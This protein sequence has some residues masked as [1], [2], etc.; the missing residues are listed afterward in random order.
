MG[1]RGAEG[2]AEYRRGGHPAVEFAGEDPR[3]RREVGSDLRQARPNEITLTATR[4]SGTSRCCASPTRGSTAGR[5]AHT[6]TPDET[7]SERSDG[8]EGTASTVRQTRRASKRFRGGPSL[9]GAMSLL[10]ARRAWRANRRG[11]AVGPACCG[12]TPAGRR[13][14]SSR[15]RSPRTRRR[16]RRS[17]GYHTPDARIPVPRACTGRV[18]SARVCLAL[19]VAKSSPHDDLIS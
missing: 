10:L 2:P 9:L 6:R 3:R 14:S 19:S 7:T 5:E 12:S 16:S 13:C 8:T 11:S 18:R 15:R 4:T 1:E 17:S